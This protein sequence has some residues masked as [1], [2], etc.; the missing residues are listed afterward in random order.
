MHAAVVNLPSYATAIIAASEVVN[1]LRLIAI[2]WGV[3]RPSDMHL[4]LPHIVLGRP[5]P[6]SLQGVVTPARL[7]T[8]K[9]QV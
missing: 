1:A 8:K 4:G 5:W 3:V 9:T 2:S 7:S 6:P